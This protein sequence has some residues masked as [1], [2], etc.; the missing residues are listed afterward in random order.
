MTIANDHIEALDEV[1]P[2]S[3]PNIKIEI[4]TNTKDRKEFLVIKSAVQISQ[5]VDAEIAERAKTFKLAG[6]KDKGAPVSIVK[7][8]IG[9]AVMTQHIDKLIKHAV[10]KVVQQ[11]NL[12]FAI[13]PNIEIKEF[14]PEG[15]IKI[16]ISFFIPPEVDFKD[17][18]FRVEILEL[19]VSD[20][21]V[22]QAKDALKRMITSYK[23]A[24]V[25]H[26]SANGDS[27]I[28]DFHGRLNGEEF[29]GNQ[30]SQFR[31]DI[32]DEQFIKD[33]ED[34]LVGFKKGDEKTIKVRFPQEYSEAKLAGQEVDF[35]IK[36]HDLLVKDDI[37]DIE[38]ELQKRFDVDS[39]EKLEE[40][41]RSKI[42]YD[43]NAISRLRTKKLLFEK[44][45]GAVDFALPEDLVAADF[46]AMWKDVSQ[47]IADGT[48]DTP[49]EKLRAEVM[50]KAK[51]RVKFG[52]I[53]A[54]IA[55]KNSIAVTDEDVKN[56]KE[57]EKMRRPDSSDKIDEF[58]NAKENKDMLLGAILEDK[59][60][61]FI[62]SQVQKYSISVTMN[63]FNDKYAKEMQDLI[64]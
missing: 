9:Q 13:K 60:V 57:L 28:I 21:D 48:I 15:D 35:D 39:S 43:F 64:Q 19:Q 29:D 14:N 41:I 45:D 2:P 37:N 54:D 26:I 6:F 4:L 23:E 7:R 8:Q 47:K 31:I 63:E 62:I 27:I 22:Q 10:L 42:I 18:R 20:S 30:A 61:D 16:F 33:F 53:L 12:S 46:E 24:P 49:E 50:D 5:E 11:N 17:D 3:D 1:M 52:L 44:L 25:G 40:I 55:K 34:K 58:F 32:G 56:A 59:V 36:V 51:K 38:N